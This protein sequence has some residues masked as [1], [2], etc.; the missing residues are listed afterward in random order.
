VSSEP[1][2][3]ATGVGEGDLSSKVV[4][5]GLLLHMQSFDLLK[6]GLHVSLRVDRVVLRR[7]FVGREEQLARKP[8][9][10]ANR[11]TPTVSI[12][13]PTIS[14]TLRHRK[15]VAV[16]DGRGRDVPPPKGVAGRG[17]VRSWCVFLEA[18][19][20]QPGDLEGQEAEKYNQVK[21]SGGE[22]CAKLAEDP[23]ASEPPH[24]PDRSQDAEE[25]E[26]AQARDAAEEVKDAPM[27]QVPAFGRRSR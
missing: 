11:A 15:L 5:C 20:E 19:L 4:E 25:P 1:S 10:V 14:P 16:A 26:D 23:W 8:E 18:K 27:T 9:K 6:R 17:D 24:D 12:P 3:L 2:A 13:T 22:P 21:R 7:S